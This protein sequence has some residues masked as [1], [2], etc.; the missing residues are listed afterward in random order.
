MVVTLT[1]DLC[2][3]EHGVDTY[4]VDFG[5]G[6]ELDLC[7]TDLKKLDKAQDALM[8]LLAQGRKVGSG[9]RRSTTSSRSR[10]RSSRETDPR[11]VREW[12]R[13][14]GYEVSDRGRI[15]TALVEAFEAAK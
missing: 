13:K 4:V 10:G 11:Q 12:A 5:G 6:Y 7:A 9:R 8:S 15:P 14:E 3:K 2:G 1:C